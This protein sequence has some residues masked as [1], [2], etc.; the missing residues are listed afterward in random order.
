MNPHR[1]RLR[2]TRLV[3]DV[4]LLLLAALSVALAGYALSDTGRPSRAAA[5]TVVV[6]PSP[7]GR[8]VT[9]LWFGDSIIEG[10]CRTK[11]SSPSLSEVA[12]SQLGWAEPQI[13]GAGGTGY[14]TSRTRDGV[15]VGPYTERIEAAVEGAYYDVVVIAGGNNDAS[16]VFDREEFRTAVRSVLAQVRVSLPDAHIVVLGAYSPDGKGYVAQRIV[17]S[18]ESL[19]IGATFID[20]VA[21]GWMRDRPELL[22]T[23]SFHPNDAGQYELGVRAAEALREL[24]PPELTAPR[25]EDDP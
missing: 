2:R 17:Q 20:Q 18:E 12:A 5:D 3:L 1:L 21:R 9:S 7:P 24:L 10:C 4:A 19:R 8:A 16:P 11:R 22:H 13:V 15:R 25:A 23:D 14:V 6:T